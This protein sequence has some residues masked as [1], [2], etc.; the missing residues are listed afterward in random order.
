M[1]SILILINS[2]TRENFRSSISKLPFLPVSVGKPKAPN[3]LFSPDSE[4]KNI[5]Y[6]EP[7]FPLEPFSSGQCLSILKSCGLK[8]RASPQ[9][10]V[11]I[12]S[13][14][15]SP[16]DTFPIQVDEIKHTRAK[17]I[18]TYI[19]KWVGPQLSESVYVHVRGC[20]RNMKFSDALKELSQN[21]SWLPV[22]SSPP[23]DYPSWLSWKGSGYTSHLVSFGSSVLLSKKQATYSFA[24]GSQ[25]F[26]VEHCFQ[27]AI[28]KVFSSLPVETMKHAMAHLGQVILRHSQCHDF[29]EVRKIT[30][31]IYQLLHIYQRAGYTVH[32]TMLQ[33]TQECVWISK[34]KKFVHPH[35]IA[36]EQNPSFRQN[37]EPF[38]YT[39]PGDL[40]RFA[41]LF[42]ALGVKD[43]V[44][45]LQ[46]L[47]ILETIKGGSSESLGVS[48]EQAWQLVM[49]ILN[50]LTGSGEHLMEEYDCNSLFVPVEPDTEWPTLVKVNDVVYTDSMFLRQ[51]LESSDC[52][53]ENYTFV[54]HRV[55]SQLAH[56]LR[57]T[58][59]STHLNI[60][61][62]AFEDVG[63]NEPLTVRLKNIL[64]DYKDGLT[65]VKEMLQNADDAGA[66]EM[67]ICYDTR[68]HA[69]KRESLFF[70]GMAECHGPALVVNN[71]A[72]F[73]KE[74]FLNITKLAGA[75][76]Q[77]QAL[78]IGKF[79]V[80]F[81]S[82]YHITD[83]PSFVSDSFLYIFD[84]T[85]SYLKEEIKNPARPGKKICFTSSFISRSKQLAPYVGLFGFDSQSR[86]KGTTFRFPFRT[87]ASEL[88]GKIYTADDM[89]QLLEHIQVCSSKLLI[90]LQYIKS[91]TFSQ[92]DHGQTACRELMN[93][94][95]TTQSL[96]SR[97]ICQISCSVRG[98]LSTDEYWL[99]E[100]STDTV[101]EKYS[102]ASVACSLYPLP[103]SEEQCYRPHKI[104]GEMFCFLSLSIETGLPVHVSSNFAVSNN[105]RG[106]WTSDETSGMSEEV[107]WNESLMEGV[108]CSAY[109]K[110][111]ERL[112]EMQIN[113]TLKEYEFFSMWPL[114]VDVKVYN[115]WHLCVKMIYKSIEKLRLFFSVSTGRWL[116]IEDGRFL[117]SDILKVPHYSSIP[118]AVLD[119]V[120][121]LQLPIVHLPAKYQEH[122][123]LSASTET[124]EMFL[125]HFFANIDQLD[126][127][128]ESRNK[129]LCFALQ[130]Y[131]NELDQQ[132]S[133]RFCYLKKYL[134][135][136]ASIPCEPDGILLGKPDQ[137][138]HPHADF[139]ELYDAD[140]TLFPLKEFCDK[141]LV[142]EAMKDLGMFHKYIPLHWLEER[143][144][145]IA[146]L[147]DSDPTKAMKRVKLIIECLFKEDQRERLTPESC[148]TIAG[149]AFLPVLPKPHDYPL[150][151]KGD[152]QKLCSG[153]A[154]LLKDVFQYIDDCTN[155]YIAGSQVVFLNQ[156]P[157]SEGGCGVINPI[158]QEILQIKT[159]PSCT[160][161]IAHFN[162][163]IDVFNGSPEMIKWADCMSRKVYEFLDNLLK[164]GNVSSE[165]MDTCISLLSEKSCIW[166]G[167]GFVKSRFV[168]QNWSLSGPYLYKIPD[169]LITCK[170]LQKALRLKETFSIH[171]LVS[172]L[173]SLKTDFGTTPLP[174]NHQSLVRAI[175]PA[176]PS[177]ELEENY[178]TFMLPDTN[179]VMEDA[180][181]L[182]FNDM[183]WTSHDSNYTFLHPS[184]PLATAKALGVQFCRTASLSRYSVTGS[185]FN[186]KK[187]GQHE[188]L[189]RRIQNIL[190]DYPFDVTILKELLLPG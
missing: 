71:N 61:E 16:A 171:D 144:T 68:Y 94:T 83:I 24:C 185:K 54:N 138:I 85:L 87:A 160:E 76:K 43:A 13:S 165:T 46:I 129:V 167:Q 63:Q 177:Q 84:P 157:P 70:P 59:L 97:C 88:S 150:P 5:Y 134:K 168:A 22:Q 174:E 34:Q 170:Y 2:Q 56:Q 102:T 74:D 40:D 115:P 110:L 67:N 60:S 123:N 154:M 92:I 27:E 166:T 145:R 127:V 95:K 41:S 11:D 18:L 104:E 7:V 96:G 190:R 1:S 72:M 33:D 91:L 117:D 25:M 151:W 20:H 109:C 156:G 3:T 21:N 4:L 23:P 153:N 49:N 6:Q 132:C 108:I 118:S 125:K 79:G 15:S 172:V 121:H 186:V 14:I 139:A 64:K 182:F 86:Y 136:N 137:L 80:G 133:D 31:A 189:T 126:S 111:L 128:M 62:D 17:A 105:R 90:F 162:V 99:V 26:F 178:G 29:E 47:G 184:V 53:E 98:S 176:L 158:M 37:L 65:I 161:V 57:L 101:L 124:E 51:F 89:T 103:K 130:C 173:L 135:S 8:T 81:C 73:T 122:L 163:L 77:S 12:I 149:I 10:V 152:N 188:E 114:Q 146:A 106:I 180:T 187:F 32:L 75:T 69:E 119:I 112:K 116:T 82:V 113:F 175:L 35:S 179:F 107:K 143:A 9:E 55:S 100:T 131:T 141:K 181:K 48:N 44:T 58:P 28:C 164:Q 142:D 36:L 52:G 19:S 42:K 183:P 50:W 93:I 148:T 159:D 78:K 39:L 120:N 140:E 66:S 30:H 45:K 169:S 147:Y 155:M 38:V